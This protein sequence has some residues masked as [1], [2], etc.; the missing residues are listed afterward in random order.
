VPNNESE[1][2]RLQL[3]ELSE[4]IALLRSWL[5]NGLPSVSI[6]GDEAAFKEALDAALAEKSALERRIKDLES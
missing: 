5:A 2:L 4:R 1:L 3:F 6:E